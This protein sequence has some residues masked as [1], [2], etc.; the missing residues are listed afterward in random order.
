MSLH[1]ETEG[2]LD[3][4]MAQEKRC[5]FALIG[6]KVSCF[7]PRWDEQSRT[8]P[9]RVQDRMGGL[10]WC[11][12]I[13]FSWAKLFFF[14]IFPFWK[15]RSG[16]SQVQRCSTER[17][18]DGFRKWF[19]FLS[20]FRFLVSKS[21]WKTSSLSL[22]NSCFSEVIGNVFPPWYCANTHTH[23]H[24]CRLYWT[25]AWSIRNNDAVLT[26]CLVLAEYCEIFAHFELLHLK[27]SGNIVY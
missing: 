25:S 23:T 3:G 6:Q 4:G 18:M 17:L 24:V 1:P 22:E 14:C 2:L 5:D 8:G 27:N 15:L 20:L 26:S 11:L 9:G 7:R 16:S 10:H 13:V 19:R 12:H 21:S